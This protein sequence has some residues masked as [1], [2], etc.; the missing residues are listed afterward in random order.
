MRYII[1]YILSLIIGGLVCC[2]CMAQELQAKIT[3]NTQKV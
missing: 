3:I 1:L 2:D